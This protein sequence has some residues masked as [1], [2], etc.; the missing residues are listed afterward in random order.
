[1]ASEVF[2]FFFIAVILLNLHRDTSSTTKLFPSAGERDVDHHGVSGRAALAALRD[3]PEDGAA[4]RGVAVGRA[5][6][7][8]V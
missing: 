3:P 1:M 2:L 4:A 7:G 6:T 5:Q 8:L